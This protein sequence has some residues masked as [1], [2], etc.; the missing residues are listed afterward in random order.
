MTN[1]PYLS[2]LL[3]ANYFV[4]FFWKDS[5][6]IEPV[7]C[8]FSYLASNFRHLNV[9]MGFLRRYIPLSIVCPWQDLNLHEPFSP[10]DFTYHYNFRYQLLVRFV[11]NVIL[12]I[13][14]CS[15][16]YAFII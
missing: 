15:L 6:G 10:L 3:S 1:T 11:R 9:S 8:L 7:D 13:I 4:V 16:D 5:A 2:G 12:N 14:V